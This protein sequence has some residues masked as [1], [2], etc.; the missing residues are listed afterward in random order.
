MDTHLLA[1][2]VTIIL[3]TLS[4]T[5]IN[6]LKKVRQKDVIVVRDNGNLR[7]FQ[8]I[9]P[10]SI[11]GAFGAYYSGWDNLDFS[12]FT[13]TTG[14]LM[15]AAGLTVRW[16]AVLSLG[17]AFTVQLGIIPDHT[18][19]TDG[20]YK[21][22]RHPGYSGMLLYYFGL[23]MGMHNWVSILL[24]IA[25]PVIVVLNRIKMEE[26]LLK[27]HFGGA[28]EQYMLVAKKLIPMVY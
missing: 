18:L 1:V 5:L 10:L 27:T 6:L 13:I 20:I 24:L 22:L 4:G 12:V 14:F 23:G 3:I 7:L 28:Y 17:N 15:V 16:I 21:H 2:I 11:I 8:F 9:I 19:K 25:G 26:A